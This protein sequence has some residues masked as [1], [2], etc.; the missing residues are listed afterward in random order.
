MYISFA[1]SARNVLDGKV[2]TDDSDYAAQRVIY[3]ICVNLSFKWTTFQ[4]KHLQN[5]GVEGFRHT[6]KVFNK[7]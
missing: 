3:Q 7:I 1:A 5:I 6:I 4:Y 2:T